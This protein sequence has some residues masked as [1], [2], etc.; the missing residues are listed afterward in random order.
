[1]LLT[2]C[3]SSTALNALQAGI[4]GLPNVGKVSIMLMNCCTL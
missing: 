1:M 2:D 3:R 4:V